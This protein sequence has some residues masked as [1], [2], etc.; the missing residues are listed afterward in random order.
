M[1]I[2]FHPAADLE[3]ALQVA[4]VAAG[5]EAAQ[6]APEVRTADPRH[7]DFQAN[8]VLGY[9]KAHRLNP[10]KDVA[11][12][13]VAAL[14]AGTKEQFDVSIAGP[15]FINFTLKPAALLAWLKAYASPEAYAAGA[16][17]VSPLRG[18]TWIVDY[19]SPNTAKQMHVGHLRSAVI[20]E[21][22]CRLLAFTGARIIRDNHIGDWGTQ[23]GKLIWAYKRQLDAAALARDP[24][25]EFERLYKAGNNAAEADPAVLKEAQQELVKLQAGDTENL[26]IWKKINEVSM[27]AFQEI[28]DQ[29]GLKFDFTLG[30]SFYNDKVERV[31]RELIECGLAV[32]SEGALVVFHPE[33]P[34]FAKQPFIIRKSDGAANYASTDLATI[35]Y[36][37]EHF[38]TP[39]AIYVVDS[40]QRDHFEQLTATADKW[41]KCKDRPAP[42][43]H[44]VDFGTVLGENNKPLKTRSGENIRLKDL[45]AEAEQRAFA[46]VSEK[47]ADIP[48][49]ERRAIASVVGTGSVQYADLSQNRS[50][51]YVFA[52]DKMISL[53]GNT[54]AYLLYAA[55]RIHSIFRKQ[56]LVPGDPAAESA[57]GPLETPAELALARK[58]V[59]FADALGLAA[60]QLRPHFLCTYLYE[61]AGEFSTFYN[62]DKVIVDDPVVRA[63]R[64]LLCAR[65]LLV[66]ETGLHLLGLRTLQRM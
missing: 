25:E 62:A 46:L 28:Y 11:E 2:S 18:Q 60:G 58:L 47:S 9:A 24:L 31:Y 42:Q 15:G 37:W 29:L 30:E 59:K 14:P 66:L 50:S 10:R 13:L 63:R 16:A 51:D 20:G 6:F 44:H 40:R 34:R 26:T 64:L 23:F 19:S 36:R 52:W 1:P 54:A 57:A 55:A 7:G 12:K 17:E 35:L 32:E 4:A 61:L 27:V 43:I 39:R 8:G 21:A 5:L 65:T 22:I 56:G 41:F 38:K 53:D 3:A 49:A 33:H 48:E 45:L